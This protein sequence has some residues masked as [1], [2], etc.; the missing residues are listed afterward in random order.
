M[1]RIS[2][3]LLA[4]AVLACGGSDNTPDANQAPAVIDN[5]PASVSE[6]TFAASLDID[7]ARFEHNDAGLYWQDVVVGEGPVVT[8]G[9]TIDVHYTGWLLDGSEFDSSRG[10][11][12]ISFPIGVG[13]V[14]AG[15]DQG[16]PGMRVGGTRR[17]IIP[18]QLAYGPNATGPIPAN[19]TL[20]F[21]VE[22][23]AAR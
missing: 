14:I 1:T 19:A 11:G 7:L 13:A 15:W 21:T 4:V 22:V 23:V 16:V 2:A 5:S 9:Q 3:A 20:V 10:G 12:P 6:A 18:G 17:L 8:A